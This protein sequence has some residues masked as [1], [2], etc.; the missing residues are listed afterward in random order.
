MSRKLPVVLA[1]DDEQFLLDAY[2]LALAGNPIDLITCD[3]GSKAID[4]ALEKQPVL[5]FID[6]KM[7]SLSGVDVLKALNQKNFHTNTYI[8]S[9]FAEEYLQDLEAL[10]QEG[11]DFEVAI[12]PLH[13]REIR[14]IVESVISIESP[15]ASDE[16]SKDNV[17]DEFYFLV[18]GLYQK[19]KPVRKKL[20]KCLNDALPGRF[21]L[22]SVDVVSLPT[23]DPNRDPLNT[24][25]LENLLPK[26]IVDLATEIYG[27]DDVSLLI[28]QKQNSKL[29]IMV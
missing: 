18:I 21:V 27:R 29:G 12:K 25:N 26:S 19:S 11:Y 28:K 16:T 24:N 23:K 1:V 4:I 10:K 22:R 14:T 5:I 7:P 8:V 20:E 17:E 6:L 9:A 2:S 13:P 15:A 3:D